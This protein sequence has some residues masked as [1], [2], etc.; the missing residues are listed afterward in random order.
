MRK[1][2]TIQ[3]LLF[4]GLCSF[5]DIHTDNLIFVNALE[6]DVTIHASFRGTCKPI[7]ARLANGDRIIMP[8]GCVG[9]GK[10]DATIHF[11]PFRDIHVSSVNFDNIGRGTFIVGNSV[12][13]HQ[14]AIAGP[15]VQ[16]S[17]LPASDGILVP[18]NA[19]GQPISIRITRKTLFC[20]DL[21]I[22]NIQP[23]TGR[24]ALVGFC[25]LE[26]IRADV[27]FTDRSV[28]TNTIRT[29]E[30]NATFIVRRR[31]G[32]SNYIIEGPFTDYR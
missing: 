23:H 8:S 4:I 9:S 30:K 16:G 31:P 29:S 26:T 21:I 5:I 18:V 20:P 32:G 15:L 28:S 10:L 6:F 27:H 11:S 2:L 25:T 3:I 13:N 14:Y 24:E 22:R 7:S 12:I 17:G 19:T 1:S